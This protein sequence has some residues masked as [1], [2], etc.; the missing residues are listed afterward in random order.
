MID[1]VLSEEVAQQHKTGEGTAEVPDVCAGKSGAGEGGDS[2]SVEARKKS[3][4]NAWKKLHLA[5]AVAVQKAAKTKPSSRRE[6]EGEFELADSDEDQR[7]NEEIEAENE[8]EEEEEEMTN[9]TEEEGPSDEF[10]KRGTKVLTPEERS[11]KMDGMG[12]LSSSS[13]TPANVQ[14][15]HMEGMLKKK[16]PH[17][18]KG[19]VSRY[20]VL[21]Q[22]K[23][24]YYKSKHDHLALGTIDF[25]LV[26]VEI[27]CDL[28]LE[29]EENGEGG[30]GETEVDGGGEKS[31][32]EGGEKEGA[33]PSPSSD[34]ETGGPS[35]S[36]PS[37]SSSSSASPSTVPKYRQ[38]A[39]FFGCG[40]SMCAG[41][42]R[43]RAKDE[44]GKKSG[45]G[46]EWS[47]P[48]FL[49]FGGERETDVRLYPLGHARVFEL[50][51][52]VDEV[53]TWL[54]AL[55]LHIALA[56]PPPPE[57]LCDTVVSQGKFWKHDRIAPSRFEE[58]ADTGDLLLFRSKTKRAKIQRLFTRGEYD[59]VGVLLRFKNSQLA[60]LEATGDSGVGIVTWEE[61]VYNEWQD[62]YDR[63]VLRRVYFDR[64]P[65][66]LKA[67][68]KFCKAVL[69]KPYKL[70]ASKLMR[71]N[72]TGE[73]EHFFCSELA[74]NSLKCLGVLPM[75]IAGS[76]YWPSSFSQK[77]RP[78]LKLLDGC[79]IGDEV[80]IDFSLAA[81]KASTQ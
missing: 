55:R 69:G 33:S 63:L 57:E 8:E 49:L 26:N 74:A 65:D 2:A 58:L 9:E 52:S 77:T 6:R 24:T 39:C 21:R 35:S 4:R 18:W 44:K 51:G 53:R 72:S 7:A 16:S 20:F 23:L 48:W 41:D 61:F 31:K 42:G 47:S 56:N 12:D 13:S 1:E 45:G 19:W 78:P 30:E 15:P 80:L 40:V 50:R 46:G 3:I 66:K 81:K 11:K 10:E 25:D 79:D 27:E 29:E 75:D 14:L 36:S 32:T 22:K 68:S 43:R 34:T 17:W 76:L 64:K 38:N 5:S 71:R 37:A 59:H 67:F 73:N 62:L 54:E 28:E 60:L 70:S